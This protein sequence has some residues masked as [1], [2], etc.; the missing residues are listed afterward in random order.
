MSA[1]AIFCIK[2]IRIVN[3]LNDLSFAG[4]ISGRVEWGMRTAITLH[5]NRHETKREIEL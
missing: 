1:M 3:V 2:V 5:S 4:I